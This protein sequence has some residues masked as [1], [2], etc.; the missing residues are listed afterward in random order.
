MRI[1][2]H[3]CCGPC[4]LEPVDALVAEGHDVEIA[5]A[6]SNIHPFPEY[7]LRRDTLL[8]YAGERGWGVRELDYDPAEWARCIAGLEHDPPR[9]CRA[10]YALRL[11][12]V[13][14]EAAGSDFDAI[15]TTL[16]VSPYQDSEAIAEA[17]RVAARAAG[18]TYLARDYR[19]RYSVATV[20]SRALGMYRQNYCGCVYSQAEAEAERE[21][22]RVER[23]AGRR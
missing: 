21:A 14:R 9:R 19:D 18:V 13:A 4:L 10:C 11:D 8:A 23:K 15:A 16:T 6:N 2:L 5:Y 22:R 12:A 7:E 20:R 3:A 1:L 17:G